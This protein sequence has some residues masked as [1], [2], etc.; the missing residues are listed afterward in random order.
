MKK[1]RKM[2]LL[3]EA[4]CLLALQLLPVQAKENMIPDYEL[5]FLLNSDMV[6]NSDDELKKDYR[7][8]F[9]TG[10]S[11]DKISVLY[12]ETAEYDFS[13]QGWYNRI[14]V[15][16]DADEFELTYKKRYSISDGDI[17]AAL[18]L[19]NQEGFDISD[20]NYEAEVDWGYEKMTLSL[21][22]NKE[23]SNKGYDDLE[24]PKK[25]DAIDI[26]KSNMP[27]KEENWLYDNWGTDTIEE[28][29]KCGPLTYLKY[30]G[31]ISGI[32]IVVEIWPITNKTSGET[33]YLTELSFKEDDYAAAVQNRQLV[34][35]YLEQAGIL[36]H[37]D[38]LKTQRI[39]A[40]YLE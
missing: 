24:L 1:I 30:K 17:E 8:L 15:K 34:M 28:G 11:Y 9:N 14:R 16:E 6:L 27:G 7:N 33:T 32:D 31:D 13:E 37:E 19:A 3:F 35:D 22:R 38:S 5:K 4:A 29:K 21:S 23:A 26:L 36:L 40:A 12:I 25:G 10:K 20:T 39:L 18:T 2:I